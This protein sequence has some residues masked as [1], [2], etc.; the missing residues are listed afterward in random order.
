MSGQAALVLLAAGSG[1]RTGYATNK[2][3]RC[4]LDRRVFI[5]TL[6][7]TRDDARIGPVVLVVRADEIQQARAV[8]AEEAPDRDVR[9]VVGGATRHA[10]EDAAL[11]ALLPLIEAG[12]IDVVVV[13]D[14]ARPLS[15]AALFAEVIDVARECGGAVPGRAQPALLE[16]ATMAPHLGEVVGVQTPQAFRADVL[17]A[18]YEAAADAGFDGSDTAASVE[19]F[20]PG[21]TVRHV[22]GPP[23]NIKITYAEDLELAA[24]LA[25]HASINAR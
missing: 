5:W 12:Q 8:L 15:G 23:T 11:A 24:V 25:R 19:R 7:S 2:A 6:D 21:V 18:A 17:V 10:S 13:H 1:R 14:A 22:P 9:V 4:L 16:R 20:M 3:F